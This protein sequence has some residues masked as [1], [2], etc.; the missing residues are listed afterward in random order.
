MK[1]S[2]D[3]DIKVSNL[4]RLSQVKTP[5]M[6]QYVSIKKD[7]LDKILFFRMGDFYE[8]FGHDAVVAAKILRIALTSR[9]KNKADAVEMCGVP[10]HSYE[11][12][13]NRLLLAGH[14]VAVCEQTETPTQDKKIVAR[15]VTRIVTPSTVTIEKGIEAEK[16]RYLVAISFH[17]SKKR[18]GFA[19]ASLL[20]GE[21]RLTEFQWKE[22]DKLISTLLQVKPQEILISNQLATS[23]ELVWEKLFQQIKQHYPDPP[24]IS[25]QNPF[26]FDLK[27][28]IH[29]L[30]EH[31]KTSHFEGFGIDKDNKAL[32]SAGALLTYLQET[33]QSDLKHFRKLQLIEREDVM[34]VN[35]SGFRD[36]E[37]F[38]SFGTNALHTLFGVLNHTSNPMGARQLKQWLQN[39][40]IDVKKLEKRFDAIEELHQQFEVFEQI[41]KQL[42]GIPDLSKVIGRISLPLVQARHLVILKTA[43]KQI[44]SLPPLLQNLQTF[45]SHNFEDLT[46]LEKLLD[47]WIL[48]SPSLDLNKGGFIAGQISDE[49]DELR[50]LKTDANQLLNH[51]AESEKEKTQI[52]TLKV[53]FNKIFGHFLEV[54]KSYI[55]LVPDH[56]IRKQTLANAERYVT[57]ELQELEEKILTAEERLIELECQF[58]NQL[59]NQVLDF[60]PA[61]QQAID[62]LSVLDATCALAKAAEVNNYKR[63][64]LFSLDQ[65]R[66][67]HLKASR[68]PIIER[69]DLDEAFIP[70]DIALGHDDCRIA[71]IT[72]PNMAG[73]STYM[74]QI[75]LNVLMAQ[76]GSFVAA[77]EA[78]ISVMDRLFTR[79]GASDNLSRGESTF[80]VEMNEI[81]VILNYA[82]PNS[83][84]ILDEVGRGTST[85]DG[86][87]IAWAVIESLNQQRALTLCATH[88]QELTQLEGLLEGV[89]NFHVSIEDMKNN[90][91]FTRKIGTGASHRSYGI[92]VAKLAGVPASVIRRSQ[93]ILLQ[94]ESENTQQA[95]FLPM[96]DTPDL[97]ETFHVESSSESEIESELK[98]VDVD[99][100]T[101]LEALNYLSKLIH[102]LHE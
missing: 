1:D 43:L 86:I 36:L 2:S 74:R 63:P 18:I 41:R 77:D 95:S 54:S 64:K 13:I 51:L 12:Y 34:L 80:M 101:P 5:M 44:K 39:P 6:E 71:L 65:P 89:K 88:Y 19:W 47:Q 46:P 87:S 93:K 84:V 91:I 96:L 82:T 94:L 10:Q 17:S 29:L 21:L 3:E 22:Q 15:R 20:T 98:A 60:L 52:P 92:Y 11:Y 58:F 7:H 102:R 56:Y 67:L 31:F 35:P 70:N 62:H 100:M 69:I 57:T 23:E 24:M 99:S 76:C 8:M 78:E 37:V 59:Q 81:A 9:D 79:V 85:F 53:G 97:E 45:H 49:I 30:Q 4:Q 50:S 25:A 42:K 73:K 61:L 72:G 28:N 38:Q 48:D 68:H 83:L 90:I 75:A 40:L 66:R 14:K 27:N 26:C 55:R 32:A 33:Q 16:D